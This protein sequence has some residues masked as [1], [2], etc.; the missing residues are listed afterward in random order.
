MI[1]KTGLN[2]S[3]YNYT[4][5]YSFI[6]LKWVNINGM[7]TLSNCS[8]NTLVQQLLHISSKYLD[9]QPI[10]PLCDMNLGLG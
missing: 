6:G 5:Y 1:L 2:Q 10:S 8:L 7:Y 9:K 4:H 3:L